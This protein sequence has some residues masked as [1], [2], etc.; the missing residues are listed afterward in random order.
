M[1]EEWTMDVPADWY[2]GFFENDWLIHVALAIPDE[3]TQQQVDF[4][5]ERLELE[6]GARILDLACG[7]GRISLELARRGYDVTG[8]DL[9]PRS[10]ELAREAAQ[11]E[12]LDVDWVQADMREIPEG[13]EFDAIVNVFTAFGYFDE[14]DENQR[15]LDGVAQALRPGGRFLIDT[16]NLLGL[17]RGYRERGWDETADGVVHLQEH[18]YDVLRGRNDVTW[19]FVKPDGTRSEL[20]HSVRLYTPHELAAMLERAGLRVE[21]SWGGFDGSELSFETWRLILLARKPP[22]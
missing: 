2:D 20:L 21:G 5:V 14:E 10:L 13:S 3:R 8:L 19:T 15:V 6:P 11:R 1:Q 4:V 16:I 17:V 7:H 22:T 9:S 12:E 18:R